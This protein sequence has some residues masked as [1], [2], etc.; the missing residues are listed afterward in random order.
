[1]RRFKKYKIC[2]ALLCTMLFLGGCTPGATA[3]P[4]EPP[5]PD[6]KALVMEYVKKMPLEEKIGQMM[7]VGIPGTNYDATAKELVERLHVGGVIMFDRNLSTGGQVSTLN[8]NLMAGAKSTGSKIPLYIAVDQ[9]GGQVAR[10]RDTLLTAPSARTLGETG[11]PEE[12]RSWAVK[13]AQSLKNYGFN[14]NFAPVADL[15]LTNRR[16]YG[17]TATAVTPMVEAA[18]AGYQQENMMCSLK[19]F[20]GIGKLTVDPH[21]DTSAINASQEVLRD[22][23]MA[24]FLAMVNKRPHNSYMIMVSHLVYP[25]FDKE[26]ASVSKVLITDVL[27]REW[28]YDGV[29]ITD[30]MAMGGLS[31]V[32][33]SEA[34]GIK[35]LE[36]GVNILLSCSEDPTMTYTIYKKVLEAVK[37]G[38]IKESQIND[39]VVRILLNKEAIGLWKLDSTPSDKVN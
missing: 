15:G 31:H 29:V 6:K 28:K 10:M 2:S 23:D 19:H 14:T 11:N 17:T 4:P 21:L 34:M 1:M 39:S 37:N 12:V 36:A 7:L 30:D 13:T 20:P 38:T 24:P 25:A 26:P 27:R 32:Y 33:S 5:K 16:S 35:A 8:Q 9:E 22:N 3:V 18:L